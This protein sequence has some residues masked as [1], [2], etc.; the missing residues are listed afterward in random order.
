MNTALLCRELDNFKEIILMTT[1]RTASSEKETL[2]REHLPLL[3]HPS[4]ILASSLDIQQI[5]DRLMDQVINALRA[6][7]GFVLLRESEDEEWQFRSARSIEREALEKDDFRI[8]KSIVDRVAREGES[9]LTSDAL[10]DKRFKSQA[11]VS[12]FSLKSILC[13][14]LIIQQR[15]L[16]VIYADN[17]METGVFNHQGK[18][19][20]ESIARQAAIALENARLYETLKRVHEESMEKAR[21]E[22]AAT[23]AQ[24]FQS[25]KMAAVGQLAAGVA[26]EI[27][28]PLGAIALNI[29]SLKKNLGDSPLHKRV[30]IIEKATQ[31]CTQ[32][33]QQLLRFSHPSFDAR[34]EVSLSELLSSTLA[35]IEFQL[36]NDNVEVQTA[37][38]EGTGIFGNQGE[39]SQVLTNIVLNARDALKGLEPVIETADSGP[40]MA[41]AVKQR[42]FEPFFTTKNVGSG[43]GLGLSI[44]F[45]MVQKYG[46]DIQVAS[47]PGRGTIFRVLIPRGG[48]R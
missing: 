43:L 41:P 18:I 4:A 44:T 30:E 31:R 45:Q 46:G 7:R 40:G 33:V 34:E 15:V 38:A 13:V 32:I 47:D 3:P 8:S 20:L 37:I 11:S 17:R 26:H 27:N 1:E 14:P 23:Q 35:L 5:L 2:E 39:L 25:S 21:Q 16:G 19:L 24:L 10:Q 28:N 42:I 6:E 36:R 22:L 9:V 29:S 12:L 48:T